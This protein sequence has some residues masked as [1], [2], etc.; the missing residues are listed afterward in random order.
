MFVSS[1][2]KPNW[3][4]MTPT[5]CTKTE[6]VA[7]RDSISWCWWY[8][9]LFIV[10]LYGEMSLISLWNLGQQQSRLDLMTHLTNIIKA[11]GCWFS[12]HVLWIFLGDAI[13]LEEHSPSKENQLFSFKCSFDRIEI[14]IQSQWWTNL[15]CNQLEVLVKSNVLVN[16]N[17]WARN[18]KT[19]SYLYTS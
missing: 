9:E 2:L 6:N 13:D 1:L 12:L 17:Q 19:N 10:I 15:A 5:T 18:K 8:S 4:K 14:K 3:R 16:Q 7:Q 11:H